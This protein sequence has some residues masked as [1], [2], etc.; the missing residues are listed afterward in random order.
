MDSVPY[1][2]AHQ[3]G[4]PPG[5]L[6]RTAEPSPRLR[7]CGANKNALPGSPTR[8]RPSTPVHLPG[9]PVVERL[10]RPFLVVEPEVPTQPPLQLGHDLVASQVHV[11][12]LDRPPQPLH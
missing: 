9:R 3:S 8:P 4:L 11:L 7:V 5:V 6:V 2:H 1:S 12:V 10:M